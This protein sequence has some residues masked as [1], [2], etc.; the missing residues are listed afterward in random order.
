M[1]ANMIQSNC[2]KTPSALRKE[3]LYEKIISTLLSL[4]VGL[5][6]CSGMYTSAFASSEATHNHTTDTSCCETLLQPRLGCYYC[7]AALVPLVCNKDRDYSYN[8]SHSYDLTKTC[9]YQVYVSTYRGYVCDSCGTVST[10]GLDLSS[11]HPCEEYHGACGDRWVDAPEC[12]DGY[13][14]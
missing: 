5:S 12:M 4:T 8:L 14:I 6:F 13:Y 1:Y 11:Q 10:G 9:T 3:R 7:Q 2:K